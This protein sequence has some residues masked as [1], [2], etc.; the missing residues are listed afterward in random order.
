[1]KL[2]KMFGGVAMVACL[3]GCGHK[4]YWA[5]TRGVDPTSAYQILDRDQFE[6]F[7]LPRLIA[8]ASD[9][10]T[11]NTTCTAEIDANQPGLPSTPDGDK[12]TPATD[13]SLG[14]AFACFRKVTKG[15]PES[16]VRAARNS[17]QERI[18][19]ASTQ[20]C[21]VYE[22]SL[23]R[24]FARNNFGAGLLAT[25]AATAGALVPAADGARILSGVAG[26]ATGY[27]A[28]FNQDYMS[29]LAAYVITEGIDN[30]RQEVYAQ[31]QTRGQNKGL[32]DYPLEAAVKDAI[33]YHGQCSVIVGFQKAADSIKLVADPGMDAS[34]RALSK[35]NLAKELTAS[36]PTKTT[37]AVIDELNNINKN[38]PT[39][40]RNL[41]GSLLG[42]DDNAKEWTL[43]KAVKDVADGLQRIS[44]KKDEFGKQWV[45]WKKELG[46]NTTPEFKVEEA[47]G[48]YGVMIDAYTKALTKIS[49]I[50]TEKLSGNTGCSSDSL[51]IDDKCNMA[52]RLAGLEQILADS[53]TLIVDNKLAQL[54]EGKKTLDSVPTTPEAKRTEAIATFSA[55][56]TK[57]ID[58]GAIIAGAR[59]KIEDLLK[60]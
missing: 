27:R 38:W 49:E 15:L 53:F 47:I 18:L 10:T 35:I 2:F 8:S 58:L 50:H 9:A 37:S 48:D 45:Q 57:K 28:E 43:S 34:I 60:K 59:G 39:T 36:S 26:V 56:L 41:A 7:D 44:Q 29:N 13:S 55:Q 3:A 12:V 23:Q 22:S 5:E 17:I 33:Y 54:T 46:P 6:K 42:V 52:Y 19:A 51:P 30:R 32:A 25:I 1:M 4:E 31:I 24:T 14:K 11:N 21:N 16:E 40:P 20:R